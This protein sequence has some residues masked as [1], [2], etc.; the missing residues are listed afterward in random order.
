MVS[1]AF[2]LCGLVV[3][4]CG[5]ALLA[6]RLGP[7]IHEVYFAIMAIDHSIHTLAGGGDRVVYERLP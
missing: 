6:V 5:S 2:S 1:V 3:G 7:F 4:V